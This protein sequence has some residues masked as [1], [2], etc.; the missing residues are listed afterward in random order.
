MADKK[1]TGLI[2]GFSLLAI[3][4]IGEA[5]CFL[6]V[7]FDS[8]YKIIENE[9]QTTTVLVGKEQRNWIRETAE[10]IHST[11]LYDTGLWPGVRK[12]FLPAAPDPTKSLDEFG[13]DNF[14][15]YVEGRLKVVNLALYL[16]TY[17]IA[18][19]ITWMPV[20]S[21]FFIPLLVDA[22]YTRKKKQYNFKYASPTVQRIGIRTVAF[23]VATILPLLLVSPLPIPPHAA[24]V[25]VL[26]VAF[27]IWAM[28]R[29]L[30]KRI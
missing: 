7:D 3:I 15:P 25:M 14:F 26:L 20:L 16:A 17:R 24:P 30:P 27:A 22:H 13:R 5:L 8:V 6:F 10:D 4:L 23:M 11:V 21:V 1:K 2:A 12:L 19:L 29:N 18:S 9:D 28:V